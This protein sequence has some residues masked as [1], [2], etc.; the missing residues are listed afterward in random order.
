ML[1]TFL[2]LRRAK[3]ILATPQIS[4]ICKIWE[5]PTGI[6]IDSDGVVEVSFKQEDKPI[7][8]LRSEPGIMPWL[9]VR[10]PSPYGGRTVL[11]TSSVR[12]ATAAVLTLLEVAK[13]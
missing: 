1:G 3:A 4:S 9:I 2:A 12:E 7:A 5:I 11:A 8:F 10:A 13:K 6:S